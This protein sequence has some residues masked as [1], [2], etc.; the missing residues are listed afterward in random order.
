[1]QLSLANPLDVLR[2]GNQLERQLKEAGLSLEVSSDFRYLADVIKQFREKTVSPMFDPEVSFL[3]NKNAFWMNARN[4][5]GKVVA[6]QAF[7]VDTVDSSLAEWAMGWMTGLY[8]LR[9]ELV[10]PEHLTPGSNSI[11]WNL[12]GPLVYQGELWIDSHV[13]KR[14]CSAVFP[15]LGM[16]LCLMKWQPTAIWGAL[17]KKMASFGHPTRAGYPYTESGFMRWKHAP[18]GAEKNEF[19]II[20]T[21][22]DLEFVAQQTVTKSI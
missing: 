2:A 20:A 22:S 11:T 16:L 21:K 8:L 14:T 18:E 6:I 12:S 13:G 19:I 3:S 9:N 10:T 7:R 15:R 17:G 5:D 1:M 4:G